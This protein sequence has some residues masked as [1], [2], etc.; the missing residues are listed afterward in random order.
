MDEAMLKQYGLG[1]CRW[2]LVRK[3]RSPCFNWYTIVTIIAYALLLIAYF[4]SHDIW[5]EDRAAEYLSNIE[6][7]NSTANMIQ[8]ILFVT[9]LGI[10]TLFSVGILAN[11]IGYG[12][13]Y[14][15]RIIPILEAICI[16]IN[17]AI[18]LRML[19]RANDS[20][21]L[22]GV[23]MLS[24]VTLF[25]LR[26]DTLKQK[27]FKLRKSEVKKIHPEGQFSTLGDTTVNNRDQLGVVSVREKVIQELRSV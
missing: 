12:M 10:L 7:S 16:L 19:S 24:A 27:L 26:L 22:F 6:D 17:T 9:E 20:K 11:I 13:L 5:F 3:L 14:I 8:T 1:A 15:K 18:L 25:I 2:S 23:K 4:F 21:G